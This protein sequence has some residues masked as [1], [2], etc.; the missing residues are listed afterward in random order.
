VS[1]PTKQASPAAASEV[2]ASGDERARRRDRATAWILLAP[3]LTILTVVGFY[4]L[5][6]SL[7]ISTT[8]YRPTQPNKEQGFVYLDN[9]ASAVTAGQFGDALVL[10]SVFTASSVVVSFLLALGL[11]VLFNT[12]RP[13]LL[14][15]RSLLLV[16]MLVTPIAVGIIWRVMMAPDFGVLNQLLA[17]LGLPEIGWIGSTSTALISVMLVD[18]WQWTP[19]MFIIIFAGLRA[20]PQSPFEAAAIDGAGPLRT[21]WNITLPML[22]PV[23]LIA[24]LLRLI[25]AV[26]TYD[27]VYIMTRGGPNLATD[28]V[29]IYLQRINFQ[30]FDLGF[31]AALSWITLLLVLATVLALVKWGGVLMERAD[32]EAGTT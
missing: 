26:R 10:T 14:I 17:L 7:Y 30:F 15:I 9:Y 23:I 24:V 27:T 2:T 11:A 3:T 6:Y 22:R 29:S 1:A 21:F 19:F 20:L 32:S 31:G 13:G 5:V 12:N 8:G 25:D 4:P 18:V 28:L 16:P